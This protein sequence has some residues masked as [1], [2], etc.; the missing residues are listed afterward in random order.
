MEKAEDTVADLHSLQESLAQERVVEG[1]NCKGRSYTV[2]IALPG[3]IVS[4]AQTLELKTYL[5]GQ[6]SRAWISYSHEY[7]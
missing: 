4:N 1:V 3:S 2:S 5:A 7:V 6:V